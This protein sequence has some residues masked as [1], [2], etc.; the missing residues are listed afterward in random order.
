MKSVRLPA[1]FIAIFAV[2]SC[3]QWGWTYSITE[4]PTFVVYA[5]VR[6][7]SSSTITVR[8][9]DTRDGSMENKVS[10]HPD[11][12]KILYLC[13][14][15][16]DQVD[17]P[18]MMTSEFEPYLVALGA[19]TWNSVTGTFDYS[20]RTACISDWSGNYLAE[21]EFNPTN[22][23][24]EGIFDKNNCSFDLE[25]GDHLCRGYRHIKYKYVYTWE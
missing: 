5:Y 10:L 24:C 18:Q 14:W 12:E 7:N 19:Q 11:E 17:Y 20:K 1:L 16:P 3:W 8:V 15:S 6:N 9:S 22:M 23:Y 21:W 4:D 25:V 2:T 13:Q